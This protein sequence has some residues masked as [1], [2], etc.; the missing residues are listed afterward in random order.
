MKQREIKFRGQRVD[1]GE[2][3][4]GLL[5]QYQAKFFITNEIV[6]YPTHADPAGTWI[7]HEH[8]VLPETIG[9]FTGLKDKNGKGIY[10]GDTVRILYS[11][12]P[13]KSDSDERTLHQYLNDIA[14]IGEVVY[15]GFQFGI[16]IHSDRF[17]ED[18]VH[19]PEH[20]QHGFIEVIV[21]EQ[22]VNEAT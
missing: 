15:N 17:N 19:S 16:A 1:T 14:K 4:Y 9:Q 22:P 21:K 8:Q 7:Y 3:V 13:S 20:G 11:D 10:E 12:W 6:E 2:W 5:N 18:I